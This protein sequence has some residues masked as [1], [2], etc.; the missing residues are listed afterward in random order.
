L[1]ASLLVLLRPGRVLIQLQLVL[2]V[3]NSILMYEP[4]LFLLNV[5]PLPFAFEATP[6]RLLLLFRLL[7]LRFSDSLIVRALSLDC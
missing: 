2:C 7:A 1:K 4:L 3:F 5:L 6:F